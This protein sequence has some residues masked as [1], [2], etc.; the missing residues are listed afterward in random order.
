M[1][2]A[3]R[4]RIDR[5]AIKA[6][7]VLDFLGC[8]T[9]FAAMLAEIFVNDIPGVVW[10]LVVTAAFQSFLL[11]WRREYSRSVAIGVV[12]ANTVPI[13]FGTPSDESTTFG[14]IAIVVAMFALG[15]YGLERQEDRA[16]TFAALAAVLAI[17]YSG[18]IYQSGLRGGDFVFIGIFA[19]APYAFGRTI[20]I[21]QRGRLNAERATAELAETS[22]KLREL[23]IQE[24]R[25]RI[26]RELHDV[27]A[28][29]V[30]LMGLQAGAARKVLPPGN[31]VIEASL[32]SIEETGRDTIGEFRR[33]LGVMRGPEGRDELAPQPGLAELTA[34]VTQ[35][36]D[37][38]LEASLSLGE[39]IQGLSPGLDL[40]AYRIAQE[41]LTNSVRHAPDSR[42]TVT[43]DV[44]GGLLELEVV[45]HDAVAVPKNPGGHGLVGMRERAAL[46]GGSCTADFVADRGF[47][48]RATMP[49]EY[50]AVESIGRS[51]PVGEMAGA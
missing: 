30:S 39:N 50:L 9:L 25:E 35:L 3:K 19:V 15:R 29:S 41:A 21:S 6:P 46:Y 32:R 18:S 49:A 16:R 28:H 4:A 7:R 22:E 47:V 43:A 42:V 36:C 23:A 13:F 12:S 38:G 1:E 17:A 14:L 48:V 45:S 31:A 5:A 40:A 2:F 44:Q 51:T 8:A 20:S 33:M 37:S 10:L 26:A 34:T 11:A 27:I 24:D